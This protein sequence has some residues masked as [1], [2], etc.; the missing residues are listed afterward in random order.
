MLVSSYQNGITA[1]FAPPKRS[2]EWDSPRGVVGGWSADSVRRHTKWLYGVQLEGLTGV[3]ISLTLTVRDLPPNPQEWAAL[4]RAWWMRVQR[5]APGI[6]RAHWVTEWQRRGVPHM[7]LAVFVEPGS[8]WDDN[9]ELLA[10]LWVATAGKYGADRLGQDATRLASAPAEPTPAAGQAERPVAGVTAERTGPALSIAAVGWLKYLSKHASRG[11]HHYQRQGTPD[12]WEGRSGRLW[13]HWGG[14]PTGEPMRFELDRHAGYRLRR[15]V[16]A[17][18]VADA[19][20]A[21]DWK[22]LAYARRMLK[23]S[24]DDGTAHRGVSDW[25]SEPMVLA[26]LALMDDQG[27]GIEQR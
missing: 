16:Q 18:R 9:V 3:G 19:R 1:G 24:Y 17:W 26:M 10:W 13:G 27:E 15:L 12:G 14:W 6:I 23:G 21:G 11:V 4:R 25:I 2:H 22:R 5:F 7:H 8:A 20:A